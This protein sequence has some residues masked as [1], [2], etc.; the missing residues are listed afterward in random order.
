MHIVMQDNSKN[1]YKIK[2]GLAPTRRTLT[3][4]QFFDKVDAIAAKNK[5]EEKLKEF[6]IEYVNLDF[7]NDEGLIYSGL[8]S[9]TVAQKFIDEKVDAIFAPHCNFG[10]E[11]AVAKLAKKVNKPLLIWG[12]RDEAPL[13]N[14][15]RTRDSQ[16]GLFAT[17]KVLSQFG[18]PFTY[19]TNSRV[20][21][22]VFER[23]L[24]NF[25]A[26]TSVVKSFRNLRLGQISTRPGAFWSVK[27][28]ELELLERFG[29][30]IVPVTLQDIKRNMELILKEKSGEVKS[31]VEE[32]KGRIN[33][34][35]INDEAVERIV[36]LKLAIKIWAE[37]ENLSSVAILCTAPMR[38]VTGVSA[39]F[40]AS[41]L[42]DTGLPVIC[43]TDVH[44]AITSVMSQAAVLGE[45]PTFLADLTIRHPEN[46]NA[47]LLWHCGVFPDSLK[48]GGSESVLNNHY[49][50]GTPGT[51]ELEI[52]GGDIT[53]SRFD[54][55]SGDYR[56]LMSQGKGVEGPK[57]NGSY[58]WVEFKDWPELE[59]RLI[60]GPYIHHVT[61]V[62][63]KIAPVLY[64][65]C[66]Y[67]PGL[68]PDPVDPTREE[69][70][71]YLIG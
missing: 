55:L 35:L 27:Y 10:T 70:E 24:K 41:E 20:T 49:G 34:T 8:D 62:H 31:G 3:R 44:G 68:T 56:L 7:L 17:T 28:N 50:A 42:T 43:E 37:Q 51:I 32:I 21:D 4:P 12:P 22:T 54:G 48:K 14:G 45:T 16:C 64:E 33:R 71:K 29:I 39:C 58:V 25:V 30:E 1:K 19:I 2:L 40:A 67:I 6:D 66:R 5:I 11:D 46:D 15:R 52:K 36:A 23:G 9:G 26:A 65:A 63:G 47:E 18:I 13:E 59:H 60:Y 57:T 53:I 69:I 61:G 38:E